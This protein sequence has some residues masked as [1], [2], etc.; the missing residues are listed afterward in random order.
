[1]RAIITHLLD[2]DNRLPEGNSRFR[3]NPG[4]FSYSGDSLGILLALH[5]HTST[6]VFVLLPELRLL[7]SR[8]HNRCEHFPS[9]VQGIVFVV[10]TENHCGILLY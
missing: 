8:A 3:P 6:N 1:M 5:G 7:C 2:L 9:K 10:A 4:R